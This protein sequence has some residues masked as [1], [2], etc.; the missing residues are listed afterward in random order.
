MAN[1]EDFGRR[2]LERFCEGDG[3]IDMMDVQEWAE[4]TGCLRP[5]PG[6]YDPETHIDVT[7]ASEP[8]DPFYMVSP[9]EPK[10]DT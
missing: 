2:V 6:G 9:K 5:V 4:E 3:E 8:G 10:N 1:W 7:G